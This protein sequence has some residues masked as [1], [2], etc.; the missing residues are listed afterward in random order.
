MG[1]TCFFYLCFGLGRVRDLHFIYNSRFRLPTISYVAHFF[2]YFMNPPKTLKGMHWY[3][4]CR[5]CQHPPC[6]NCKR[7]FVEGPDIW[8]PT[9]CHDKPYCSLAC[10]YPPCAYGRCKERRPTVRK[11]SVHNMPQWFC[12]SHKQNS[13][14]SK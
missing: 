5:S 9:H 13:K 14:G 7:S 2:S 4:L 8:T 3:S 12:S 10:E 1:L 11:Y 6:Y